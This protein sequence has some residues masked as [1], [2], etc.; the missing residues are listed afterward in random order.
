M[1]H[2]VDLYFLFFTLVLLEGI[3]GVTRCVFCPPGPCIHIDKQLCPV[4]V[5]FLLEEKE[6]PLVGESDS[7][8]YFL[9][10]S[11]NMY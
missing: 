4:S 11:K 10:C 2:E 7:P 8:D 3:C 5:S 6:T 1:I 9:N